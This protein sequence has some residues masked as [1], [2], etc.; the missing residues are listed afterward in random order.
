MALFYNLARV[1]TPTTGTGTLTLGGA[2]TGFLT[3]AQSGV[4]NGDVV[5]YAIRDGVNS[6]IGF[7]T[8]TASGATLTRTVRKSTNG[9]AAIPLSGNAEV[10]I[11]PSAEDIEETA[12][13][14]LAAHIADPTGAHAASAIA[15]TPVGSVA[16]TDVQ[17]AIAELDGDLT[18][19]L[20]GKQPLDADLTAIAALATAS[21][22]RSLLTL[23]DAEALQDIV[24]V[25]TALTANTTITVGSGQ[26][27]ETLQAAWDHVC[28][29][30]DLAGFDVTLDLIDGT[31]AGFS[32]YT[33]TGGIGPYIGGGRVIINGNS[34][35]PA[36]VIVTQ[37]SGYTLHI[38][39]SYVLLQNFEVRST[40]EGGIGVAWR[41]VVEF[42]SG[43]RTGA[44]TNEKVHASSGGQFRALQNYTDVGNAAKHAFAG[45][46]GQMRIFGIT[47]TLSGTPAYSESFA[48]V[49]TDGI[50]DARGTTFSGSATGAAFIAEP[51]GK[52]LRDTNDLND[53]PGNAEGT[54]GAGALYDEFVGPLPTEIAA[55]SFSGATVVVAIP[56]WAKR[57]F[58]HV[59]GVSSNTATRH[60]IILAS[61]DGGGTYP[62]TDYSCFGL[63]AAPAFVS[64]DA[65]VSMF[66]D[67]A[68]AR[69]WDYDAWVDGVEGGGLHARWQGVTDDS[70]AGVATGQSFNAALDGRITHIRFGW[71]A[72]GNHDA[73]TYSVRG[74]G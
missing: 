72:S 71:N 74:M 33:G 10:V 17:A 11:T 20:A 65:M 63:T 69:S 32:D 7:G 22:G 16:A 9:D 68:A 13:A 55:G 44:C 48:Y 31:H 14:G 3:F 26:D 67:V 58:I 60:P 5:A 34:G 28:T 40:G 38:V 50:F 45:Q 57:L 30:L 47:V 54:L 59:A 51:G 56:V 6:E 15:F 62:I 35:T 37:A 42:G 24:G 25:R 43:M 73:G 46:G 39:N 52:I 66:T 18:S 41:G 70:S 23:A 2:V 12:D 53:L 21:F 1:T 36:N 64:D 8:Y 27:F 19:G 4:Q 29:N 61:M 49:G